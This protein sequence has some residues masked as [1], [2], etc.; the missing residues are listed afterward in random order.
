MRNTLIIIAIGLLCL[1]GCTQYNG[2]IGPIFGSWALVEISEDGVP[3]E[4]ED[5]TVMSFQNEVVQITKRME[6]PLSSEFRYGNFVKTDDS[7]ILKFETTPNQY[8]NT[9]YMWPDWL[10]FPLDE[11][12]L[13]FHIIKL[14]GKRMVL[15]LNKEHSSLI[16]TF[17]RTW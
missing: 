3:L 5:E 7:L 13:S 6:P 2:Y 9:S 8:G 11:Q 16:Y 14:D 12:S 1:C 10:H 4:M 15:E 17:T